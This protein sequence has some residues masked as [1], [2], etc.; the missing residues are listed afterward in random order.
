MYFD[1]KMFAMQ[2]AIMHVMIEEKPEL[3][4]SILELA[5][6]YESNFFMPEEELAMAMR[7]AMRNMVLAT[8]EK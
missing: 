7:S 2:F 5:E 8:E 3:R 1:A 6:F 4:K